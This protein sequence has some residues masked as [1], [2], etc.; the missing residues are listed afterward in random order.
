MAKFQISGPQAPRATAPNLVSFSA[1]SSRT[2]RRR[3][4]IRTFFG[5]LK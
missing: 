4:A 2:R 1:F 3:C 5:G